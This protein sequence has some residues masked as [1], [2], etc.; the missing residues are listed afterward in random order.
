MK[1]Q[2]TPKREVLYPN[3]LGLNEQGALY[4]AIKK[5]HEL[6]LVLDEE[7][8]RHDLRDAD[9]GTTPHQYILTEN[10]EE[11]FYA[12]QRGEFYGSPNPMEE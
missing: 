5:Y 7:G 6:I 11:V 8:E 1:I 4:K 2:E 12:W 10:G 9:Q 3:I